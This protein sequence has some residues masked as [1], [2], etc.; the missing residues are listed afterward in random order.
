MWQI[1]PL[2]ILQSLLL[3]G[4]QVLLKFALRDLGDFVWS[5]PYFGRVLTSGWLLG[6][7]CCYAGGT[8]LWFYIIKHFP[9]SMAYPMISLSY[10]FGM[11]AAIFIFHEQVSV[12]AWVGIAM[13]MCGCMLIVR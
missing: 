6:C 13:I 10:V 1:I 8:I 12:S 9:F 7:G 3:A 2:S 11:L 5:W 4:G